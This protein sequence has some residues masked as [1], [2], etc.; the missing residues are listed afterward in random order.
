MFLGQFDHSLDNKGRLTIPSKYR[1]EL[2]DGL[3]ITRGLDNCLWILARADWDELAAKVSKLPTTNPNARNFSRFLFSQASDTV[4]DKQGR[5]LIPQKLREF[6]GIDTDTVIAGVDNRIEI[7]SVE[8]WNAMQ[9]QVES[10]PEAYALQ[11][12]DLGI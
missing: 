5:V 6:A 8:R 12:Q 2:E 7:W 1:P 11:L 4:P 10:N 3:V 9:E